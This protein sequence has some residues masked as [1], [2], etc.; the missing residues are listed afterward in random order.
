M[1]E[2]VYCINTFMQS[3]VFA[4]LFNETLGSKIKFP[5]TVFLIYACFYSVHIFEH[6]VAFN[7]NIVVFIRVSLVAVVV[8]F[9][10]KGTKVRKIISYVLFWLVMLTAELIGYLIIWKLFFY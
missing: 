9:F 10:Y 3:I 8:S 4:F 5:F 6:F 1:R 7:N 2:A